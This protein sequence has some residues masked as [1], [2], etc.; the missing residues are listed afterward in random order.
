MAERGQI[1]GGIL[2]GPLAFDNAIN[3]EAANTKGIKSLVAGDPDILLAPD[4]EA[5]NMLAKQ[6]SFLANADSAGLVL[7]ARVPVIVTSRA[8][9]VRSRIASCAIAMLVAHAR[10][11]KL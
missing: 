9:S 2:D 11:E 7:G 5:G 1:T 6:L 4:L 10:R 3:K 8:D